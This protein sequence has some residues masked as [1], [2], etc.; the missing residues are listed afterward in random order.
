V[1]EGEGGEVGVEGAEEGCEGG[2]EG[3]GDSGDGGGG[4]EETPNVML[5]VSSSPGSHSFSGVDSSEADR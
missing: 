1:G 2:E 4:G 3:A 5:S